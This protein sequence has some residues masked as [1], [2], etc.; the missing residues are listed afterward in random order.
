MKG[1]SFNAEYKGHNSNITTKLSV[2]FFLEGEAIISYCPALDLSAYGKSVNEA[3]DAFTKAF[4]IYITYC[5][6]K[7]TL[8][9]DLRSHGW[10]LK[11][12]KH[13]KVKAP[14][15]PEMLK[16]NP[17]LKDIIYNKEYQKSDELVEIPAFV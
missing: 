5:M 6:N 16:R 1:L 3:K 17:I 4:T 2:Y 8:A 9:D 12:L 13:R 10:E 15:I 7:N 14:T 11:S